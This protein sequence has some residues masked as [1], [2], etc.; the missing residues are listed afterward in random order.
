VRR[1]L[2]HR[3]RRVTR[4]N[5]RMT[6]CAL[7]VPDSPRRAAQLLRYRDQLVLEALDEQRQLSEQWRAL[8]ELRRQNLGTVHSL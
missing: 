3:W 5:E 6:C 8:N 2:S 4:I 7:A 1:Q